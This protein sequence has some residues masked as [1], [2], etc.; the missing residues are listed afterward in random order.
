VKKMKL[1]LFT[2]L[3][4]L[5]GGNIFGQSIEIGQ[6]GLS[7]EAL[8]EQAESGNIELKQALRTLHQAERDLEGPLTL[9]TS[10]VSLGARYGGVLLA[11]GDVSIPIVPQITLGGGAAVPLYDS[12]A[13]EEGPGEITGSINLTTRP[14][15]SPKLTARSTELYEKAYYSYIYRKAELLYSVEKVFLSVLTAEKERTDAEDILRLRTEEYEIAKEKYNLGEAAL[16]ELTDQ[17]DALSEARQS[18][19]SGEKALMSAEMEFY[20][21]IGRA[22]TAETV[23]RPVTL[24]DVSK[25]IE[26]RS[27]VVQAL[28]NGP[29]QSL[30]LAL[31]RIELKSLTAEKGMLR[32]YRPDLSVTASMDFPS[33]DL[34]AGISYSF[35]PGDIKTDEV[36]T[37]KENLLSLEE[38]IQNEL[39]TLQ[40]EKEMLLSQTRTA[41]EIL[42]LNR[43][44]Y[45]DA[46]LTLEEVRFL[47]EEGERTRVELLQAELSAQSKRTALY[48]SAVELYTLLGDFILLFTVPIEQ[49][50]NVKG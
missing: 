19:Y 16:K 3:C 32:T 4:V 36:T 29:P 27:G 6:Q 24:D 12:F 49:N 45:E 11:S 20:T 39:F 30:T 14:F 33:N 47:A 43:S 7:V 25:W 18:S 48:A 28:R 10:K 40:K 46:L 13:A 50:W 34:S 22:S 41:Y 21:V 17:A 42:N 9:D 31:L 5:T 35:S 37:L 1:L 44:A 23:I 2:L 15:A 38:K 8:V 26:R